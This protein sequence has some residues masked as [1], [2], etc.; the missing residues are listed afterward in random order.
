M[1]T[2]G[3]N[4]FRNYEYSSAATYGAFYDAVCV[5]TN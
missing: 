4:D 3:K 2:Y 5:D 1:R